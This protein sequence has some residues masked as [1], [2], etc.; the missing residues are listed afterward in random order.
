MIVLVVGVPGVGK[1]SVIKE[2][3]KYIQKQV[4]YISVGDIIF[5]IAK[6]E[7]NIQNRDEIRKV[8]SYEKQEE[9]QMKAFQKIKYLDN[10]NEILILDTHFV[11]ES[12]NGFIPGIIRK[13]AE[14]IK[15]EA[16]AVII[17]DPDKIF[18]RR[19]KD[20]N[21]RAREIENLKRI[22]IQQNMTIYFS[23]IFMYEF[24]SVVEVINNEEGLL[25][26]AAK[27]LAEFINKL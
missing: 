15:P 13:F 17:A 21:I 3:M 7:Y 27:K 8:L 20:A 11:I 12:Y 6:Q 25:E 14:I 24:H 5:E 22:E 16:I 9:L 26:E 19:L 23:L 18:L 10:P 1:T 4:K 2:A